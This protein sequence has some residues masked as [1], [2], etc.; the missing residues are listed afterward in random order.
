VSGSSKK[1]DLIKLGDKEFKFPGG[2]VKVSIESI[3]DSAAYMT[4]TKNA[5]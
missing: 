1:D 2:K 4:A 5:N 3:F